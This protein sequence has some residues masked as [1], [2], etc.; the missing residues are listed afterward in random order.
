MN[1]KR[2]IILI[3]VALL[4]TLVG[5]GIGSIN[6]NEEAPASAETQAQ[7]AEPET[8]SSKSEQIPVLKKGQFAFTAGEFS[9]LFSDTLPDG[10]SL[11]ASA[12]ANPSRHSKLQVAVLNSTG[13]DTGI[14]V[15]MNVKD[16]SESFSKIAL[17]AG[18]DGD[19]DEFAILVDWFVSTFM[20]SLSTKENAAWQAECLNMFRNGEDS[21]SDVA[22][23]E[24]V[25][26]MILE[27]EDIGRQYYIE[28]AVNEP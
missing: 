24:A 8:Q 26:M 11:A 13:E 3:F 2:V 12:A 10:Y 23:K 7:N 25:G 14:A 21:F 16:P 19:A 17:T 22:T 1:K 20:P 9:E 15:L 28:V 6:R 27:A 18:A 4:F 5:Y